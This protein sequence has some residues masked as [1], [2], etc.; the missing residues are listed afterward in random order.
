MPEE[1][2]TTNQEQPVTLADLF[3]GDNQEALINELKKGRLDAVPNA[4]LY[5]RQLEP[6][7][8]D[9]MDPIKRKDR[10]VKTDPADPNQVRTGPSK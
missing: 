3:K 8:H 2:S 4:E 7:G 1:R 9:V 5:A 10:W 6:E